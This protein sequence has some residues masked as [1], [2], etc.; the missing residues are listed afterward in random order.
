MK[1]RKRNCIGCGKEYAEETDHEYCSPQCPARTK[2][3]PTGAYQDWSYE[4]SK[5]DVDEP[6]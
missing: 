1:P 6:T 3:E 5:E 4:A 2:R